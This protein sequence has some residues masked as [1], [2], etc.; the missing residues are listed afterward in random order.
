MSEKPILFSASMIRAI[1]EGRKTQ[2]R[3]VV[4][5]QPKHNVAGMHWVRFGDVFHYPQVC[6]EIKIKS[7]YGID[8]DEIWVRETFTKIWNQDGC[9]HDDPYDTTECPCEGCHIEYKAD[10]GSKYPADWPDDSTGDPDLPTWKPSIYMPRWASRIQLKVVD[11]RIERLQDISEADARAEGVLLSG[12]TCTMYEGIYRDAFS[13]LWDGIN[14]TRSGGLY[15]WSKNPWVWRV[16]F[17]KIK[18]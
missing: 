14:S 16:E 11:I 10:S 8:G 9:L 13:I 2:T 17:S 3:R 1:L 12:R 7:P 15:A 6:P 4:R 5:V 18:P